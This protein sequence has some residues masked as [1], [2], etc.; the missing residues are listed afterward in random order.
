MVNLNNDWDA[1][2]APEF[3]KE[4]YIKLRQFLIAEYQTKTIYPDKHDIFNAFKL[5]PYNATKIVILG[6][7]PYINPSEAQGLSFSVPKNI[8]IPPSLANIFKEL[9][10]D[11]GAAIP[12]HGCLIEWAL[13]GVLLLNT[14][15]TVQQGRSHSH[16]NKGWEI[17]TDNVLHILNQKDAPVVFLL[18]GNPAKAKAVALNNPKHLV[19]TAAHPSPLAGGKFFGCRHFSKA[20]DFLA[21]NGEARID[22]GFM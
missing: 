3:Q 5:T 8:K 15:L 11:I 6:Q 17:F 10:N 18:W 13:Q 16:A 22:W 4:Y 12:P 7:D 21:E 9:H 20:N 14:V 19:L 2:L 1:L